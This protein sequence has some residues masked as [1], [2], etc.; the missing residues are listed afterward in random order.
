MSFS[1]TKRKKIY[2]RDNFTCRYCGR[3]ADRIVE[4]R[5]KRG[6]LIKLFINDDW[7]CYELDHKK[8]RS[9]SGTNDLRNL[10]T[11]CAR[12]NNLKNNKSYKE[13]VKNNNLGQVEAHTCI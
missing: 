11:S 7:R 8:P 13:F 5:G 1:Y 10:L 2:T 6:M 4:E 9:K 3:K 12:C